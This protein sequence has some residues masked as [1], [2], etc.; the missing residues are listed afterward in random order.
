MSY[1]WKLIV[2]SE[3]EV[4]SSDLPSGTQFFSLISLLRS[5]TIVFSVRIILRAANNDNG[6]PKV[7]VHLAARVYI[8]SREQ[9]RSG[10]RSVACNKV[11]LVN[12]E[13]GVGRY[14]ESRAEKIRGTRQRRSFECRDRKSGAA[15]CR[16]ESIDRRV[17]DWL[18][19]Q[20]IASET[21]NPNSPSRFHFL[22]KMS[23]NN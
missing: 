22:P 6:R 2:S 8:P 13:A 23:K 15:A 10:T 16:D 20:R 11:H 19:Q 4:T 18:R 7:A 17:T 1:H 3:V 21:I 12:D 5:P 9:P 14:A